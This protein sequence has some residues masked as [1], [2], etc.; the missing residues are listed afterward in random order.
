MKIQFT[1]SVFLIFASTFSY[2]A[3]FDCNKASN[4]IEKA[5]CNDRQLSKLDE[6]LSENTTVRSFE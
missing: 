3:S 1:A 5:I 2:A 6:M 4:F